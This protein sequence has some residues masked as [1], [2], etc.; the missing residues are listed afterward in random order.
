MNQNVAP[1][2]G[3]MIL[4]SLGL[5]L[6]GLMLAACAKE[7]PPSDRVALTAFREANDR[8]EPFNRAMFAFD[9]QLDAVLIRP[10]AWTY[11]KATPKFFQQRVTSV[12]DNARSP[13]I[14]VNDLLQCEGTHA[15]ES[16]KRFVINTTVGVGG[17]FDVAAEMGIKYHGEDFGQTLAVWGAESG[18]YLYLPLLGPSSPRDG[19]GLAVDSFLFDPVAW[20]TYNPRNEQWVQWTQLGVTLVDAKARTMDA[21]DELKKSSIDYYAAL[22]S[23]YRQIRAREIRNGAPPP[24]PDFSYDEE[25]DPFAEPAP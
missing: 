6:C 19:F 17:L 16:F 22:R 20:Y 21:T 14:F 2:S 23:A 8:L 25:E 13:I 24:T 4:R 18:P 3:H 11:K 5:A 7:P 9:Q 12:L 1:P 10:V 15:S